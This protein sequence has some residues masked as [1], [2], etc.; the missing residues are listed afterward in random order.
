[1]PTKCKPEDKT[2][3]ADDLLIARRYMTK[4]N[5]ARQAEW[6][7]TISFNEFKRLTQRKQCALSGMK[8]KEYRKGSRPGH[9][10]TDYNAWTLDRLD[11]TKGYIPGNVIPVVNCVNSFK[12]RLENPL[13]HVDFDLAL[14]IIQKTKKLL[15]K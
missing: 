2:D 8:F 12:G 7:F 5:N 15:D 14:K 10:D 6:D 1:M 4:A 3:R 11:N 13:C 9:P